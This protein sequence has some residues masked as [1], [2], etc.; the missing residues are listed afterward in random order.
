MASD[1]ASKL[2]SELSK[3]T[4]FQLYLALRVAGYEEFVS[5]RRPVPFIADDILETFD[6][7]RAE[8]TFKVFSDMARS[9]QVV[10]LTHHKHLIDIARQVCPSVALHELPA[11]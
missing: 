2:A 1:G 10:Y 11:R 6:D 3:G 4:R 7:G 5:T 9:G 8:E